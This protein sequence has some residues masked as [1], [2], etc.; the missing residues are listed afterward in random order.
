MNLIQAVFH[1]TVGATTNVATIAATTAGSVLVVGIAGPSG[2]PGGV[3]MSTS[4]GGTWV[5]GPFSG[6]HNEVEEQTGSGISAGVTTVTAT[7]TTSQDTGMWVL[8]FDGPAASPSGASTSANGTTSTPAVGPVT[9]A[10]V[11]NVVVA[12]GA[13]NVADT[14]GPTGGFASAGASG[15]FTGTRKIQ[16]AYKIQHAASAA[17]TGYTLG[18]AANWD[19]IIVSIE[20]A[21]S[22]PPTA[23]D[24]M[25]FLNA[26][27]ASAHRPPWFAPK[28]ARRINGQDGFAKG[29]FSALAGTFAFPAAASITL[30]AQDPKANVGAAAGGP[31]VTV[32]VNA[33]TVSRGSATS[34]S[35]GFASITVVV[36]SPTAIPTDEPTPQSDTHEFDERVFEFFW[37]GPWAHR[38]S[39]LRLRG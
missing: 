26:D 17:S 24:M 4:G 7:F 8:E 36:N 38:T 39:R 18:S 20:G 16:A 28:M 30:L 10:N 32:A 27:I 1:A 22:A 11:E 14:A 13:T 29:A 21:A 37:E 5:S 35:A 15:T 31:A 19:M 3:T 34:A 33:P 6:A 25:V 9:P 2:F 23:G 12:F